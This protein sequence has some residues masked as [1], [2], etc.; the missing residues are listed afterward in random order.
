MLAAFA[1]V[2]TAAL[3]I[4]GVATFGAG[5]IAAEV[6]E[7]FAPWGSG[8]KL[9]RLNAGLPRKLGDAALA[10]RLAQREDDGRVVEQWRGRLAD[11]EAG[12]RRTS[13]AEAAE[14][15]TIRRAS[16]GSRDAAYRLGRASC[17]AESGNANTSTGDSVSTT[18]DWLRDDEDLR[19]IL[20]PAG[21][22][23]SPD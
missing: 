16:T 14:R 1:G 13:E 2:K 4:A 6:Y 23:P 15:D 7:N 10:G 20:A 21:R 9:D 17:R 19:A 11:C 12:G 3:V 5:F 18:A 22:A 8:A